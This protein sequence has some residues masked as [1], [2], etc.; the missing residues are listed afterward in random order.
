MP[1]AAHTEPFENGDGRRVSRIAPGGDAVLSPDSEEVAEQRPRR[2]GR[3]A[4][5]LELGAQRETDLGLPRVL[6]VD[7]YSRSR[8]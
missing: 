3:I 4:V 5:A 8:R 1:L 2:L 7:S 6:G